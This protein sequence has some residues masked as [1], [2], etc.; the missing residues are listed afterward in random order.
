MFRKVQKDLEEISEKREDFL[1]ETFNNN[2]A[3]HEI[4]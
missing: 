2:Q 4:I 1:S 3:L